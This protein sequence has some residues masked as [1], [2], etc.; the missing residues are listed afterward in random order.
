M[1][2]YAVIRRFVVSTA[3]RATALSV[4]TLA[5]AAA[6]ALWM[7]SDADPSRGAGFAA[8]E[9][10]SKVRDQHASGSPDE[11]TG[12]IGAQSVTLTRG[13]LESIGVVAEPVERGHWPEHLRVTGRLELNEGR[14]AHVCSMVEGVVRELRA[15]IGQSVARG[16]VLA[17]VDSREVGQAKLQLVQDQLQ[18]TSARTT[19]EWH[20][21]IYENTLALLEGLE[22]GQTPDDIAQTFR[23]RPMGT[24]REQLVT[25]LSR[26]NRAR[27][28]Y[29]R[30]R[31]LGA[32][33]IVPEKE[34]IRVRAE[35]EA[36]EATY[37]AL[38]EQ[39][40]FDAQQRA[41]Q[42]QQELRAA[43]ASVAIS[44]SHLLILGYGEED[45]ASMDPLGEGERVAYYPVRAPLDG[46]VIGRS[47]PLSQHVNG[48]TELFVVADL[49]T[50]WVRA[51]VFEKD[52]Q[53]VQGLRGRSVT[54]QVASYPGRQFTA[55]IF[56]L[57]DLVDDQTRATR[58]LATADNA[59]GLLKPGMFVEIEM[60]T[61]DDA[62]VLQLPA[63]AVQRHAD[64]PFVFVAGG[65]G[66]FERRDVALGR[67]NDELVEITAGLVQGE[68]VVVQGGFALKSELLSELM[69]ED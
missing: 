66:S 60:A 39:T 61:G 46:I 49:S 27:L 24:Y 69:T 26:L 37:L 57:G 32:Q 34:V 28:D 40:R 15:E 12:T 4:A 14:V 17:Y 45:I 11:S 59:R 36:A 38:M 6:V 50:V 41:A 43:E 23:N 7:L 67:M 62:A 54:F 10:E 22:Q 47:A 65:A 53:A 63:A 55:E 30:V 20:E 58:L 25:A 29:E 56:S 1:R 9:T 42:A 3:G 44:R 52:F 64:K 33:A 8:S 13:K 18:L 21:A 35:H 68:A 51:D 5:V 48:E 2:V 31:Q 16:D 19:S